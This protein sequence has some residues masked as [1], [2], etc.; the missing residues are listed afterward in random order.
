M[1]HRPVLDYCLTGTKRL[2]EPYLSFASISLVSVMTDIPEI[3]KIVTKPSAKT[4]KIAT[5]E[6]AWVR[7]IHI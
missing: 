1:M 4:G 2:F 5:S 7:N 3:G 6:A